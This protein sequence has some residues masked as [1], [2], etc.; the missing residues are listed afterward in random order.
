MNRLGWIALGCAL[1]GVSGCVIDPTYTYCA[2]G[3]D[4]EAQEQCFEVATTRTNGAFCSEECASYLQCETNLGFPGVC[5]EVDRWGGICFQQCDFDSD[6]FGTS[7]C[8]EFAAPPGNVLSN[9]VYI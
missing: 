5:M 3:G 7:V 6:C 1:L 2:S 4:C 8:D 9:K